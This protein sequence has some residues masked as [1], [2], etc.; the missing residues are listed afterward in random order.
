[1]VAHNDRFS[2]RTFT[3]LGLGAS[4]GL[5]AATRSVTA[6]DASPAPSPAVAD[7][8][9][10]EGTG[11]TEIVVTAD[12]YTFGAAVP[13]SM[14][15]GWYV[16]TL[17]N[18]TETVAD[19]NLALLPEGTTGG[20]LS[21]AVSRIFQG[22][23][24]E[25]PEWWSSALFA[26]GSVAGPGDSTSSLVYLTPGKWYL[27]NTN[28]AAEQSPA[29]FLIQ[30]PEELEATAGII[31]TPTASPVG[32]G[33]PGATPEIVGLVNPEGVVAAVV[34]EVTENQIVPNGAPTGGEQILQIANTGDQVRDLIILQTEEAL[35]EESALALATS[36][37]R[38]EKTNAMVAG[39]VGTLSPGW[40]A[41][42]AVDVQ[43]GNYVV[44]SAVPDADGGLQVEKGIITTFSVE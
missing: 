36:W 13:G 37:I 42:T 7:V 27:F 29:S 41:F 22:E 39:G 3:A 1:M 32:V 38:G 30:T 8:G 26:G 44:F 6:Q 21:T 25:L 17:V 19:A 16:I 43:P 34:L 35:D 5:L 11:F 10:F 15:E 14:G 24:G 2:R 9:P 28:P 31:A 33:T 12:Q 4:A 40:T 20:D 23:G 18:E